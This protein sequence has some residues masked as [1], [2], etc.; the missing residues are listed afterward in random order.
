MYVASDLKGKYIGSNARLILDIFEHWENN[1]QEGLLLFLDFEKAFDSV[2]WNF[3]FKTLETF[4]FGT[5]SRFHHFAVD[6][7]DEAY[8]SQFFA[9]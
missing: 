2:E 1:N 5:N 6:I 4:N 9:L 7:S 8:Y 3:L